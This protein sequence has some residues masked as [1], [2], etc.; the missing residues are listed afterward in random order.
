MN[1]K[2]LAYPLIY[3]SISSNAIKATPLSCNHEAEDSLQWAYSKNGFF[4][5]KSAY[6]LAKGLNPL[7]RD[8]VSVE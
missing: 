4:S 5:L 6:L 1:G 7:N 3:P 8:A 2:L